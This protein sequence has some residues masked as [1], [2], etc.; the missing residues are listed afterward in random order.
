MAEPGPEAFVI[1]R[2][3][4]PKSFAGFEK[5]VEV[6]LAHVD[7]AKADD[8]CSKLKRYS[9]L[10]SRRCSE[11]QLWIQQRKMKMMPV[12]RTYYQVGPVQPRDVEFLIDDRP[13]SCS[14]YRD[15]TTSVIAA[16]VP[17]CPRQRE[18]TFGDL[19][20]HDAVGHITV[21]RRAVECAG[22]NVRRRQNRNRQAVGRC[23]Q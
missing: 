17:R 4:I 2:I 11:G 22:I 20:H 6:N 9:I 1:G 13:I 8:S 14:C 12:M 21:R 10:C 3:G 18:R 5:I 16:R 7:V 15:S 19:G 23:K